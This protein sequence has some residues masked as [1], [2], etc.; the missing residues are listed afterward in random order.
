MNP[1]RK[2]MVAVGFEKHAQ[3]LVAYAAQVAGS[4]NA[5]LLIVNIINIRDVE[6]IGSVAAMGYAIDSEQY[7]SGVKEERKQVLDGILAKIPFPADKLRAIFQIGRFR[8][9]GRFPERERWPREGRASEYNS[10]LQF[11]RK[12]IYWQWGSEA[13]PNWNISWWDL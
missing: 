3:G 8:D 11:A 10:K 7:V 2:I 4:L 9:F 12:S 6:A 5:E 13:V 1:I